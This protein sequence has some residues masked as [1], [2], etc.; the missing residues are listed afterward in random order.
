MIGEEKRRSERVV[1]F[2]SDEEVVVIH[3]DGGPS[4]LAKL[5]DLS[6]AGTLVYLL[7]EKELQGAT[8][9]SFA[10]SIYHEGNVFNVPT[11]I[12][13]NSNRLVAFQFVN[14]PPEAMRNI[15]SKLIRME[16]EWMRLSRLG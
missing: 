5:M 8:G 9:S 16:I 6:Q 15:Q 12:V 1:P 7:E 13:S 4:M 10:L 2:V 11:T 3:K 14:P